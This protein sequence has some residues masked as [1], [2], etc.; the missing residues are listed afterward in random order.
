MCV[1]VC[2]YANVYNMSNWDAKSQAT[3]LSIDVH[4]AAP[5]MATL[6]KQART[7]MKRNALQTDH[8]ETINFIGE[9]TEDWFKSIVTRPGHVR[10]GATRKRLAASKSVSVEERPYRNAKARTGRCQETNRL[11]NLL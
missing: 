5:V 11:F 8:D 3:S 4:G 7:M 2:A 6:M 9:H 1:C 10:D